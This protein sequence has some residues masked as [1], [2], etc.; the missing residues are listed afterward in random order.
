MRHPPVGIDGGMNAGALGAGVPAAA[1]VRLAITEKNPGYHAHDGIHGDGEGSV[2]LRAKVVWGRETDVNRASSRAA[3][4]GA[5][6]V[7]RTL[8]GLELTLVSGE[9]ASELLARPKPLAVLVYL[10]L[11][12]RNGMQSRD[13]LLDMFWPEAAADRA[14]SSL[15]QATYQ[16]R[17]FLGRDAIV[18]RG[19]EVGITADALQCDTLDFERRLALGDRA[20]ALE[21]YRGDLLPGFF[22]DGAPAFERWLGERR[23]RLRDAA[24]SAAQALAQ[25]AERAGDEASA[26]IWNRRAV[27]L[28]PD[29]EPSVRRLM[30]LLDRAGDRAGAVRAYE[31]FARHMRAVLDLEPSDETAAL[32]ATMRGEP[33]QTSGR[34]TS[35]DTRRVLV[36]AFDNESACDGLGP[37]GRLLA[38]ALATSIARLEGVQVVPLTAALASTRHEERG[39][40]LASGAA[41]ARAAAADAGAATVVT[42]AYY[43]AEGQVMIQG[44]II[45]ARVGLVINALGPASA[46]V[47]HPLAA[48]DALCDEARTT[49]ARR[50]ET[51]VTHVRAAARAPSYEAHVEYVEGIGRFVDGDWRRAL[52][53][54]ERA[55]TR[56][57]SYAL[58][59]IVSA[60]A[61]WNLGELPSADDAVR[62]AGPLAAVA[63]P[64]ERALLDMVRAWLSG[65]WGTAY[66]AVRRQSELAPGSIAVF[67]M[68]EEAR[69]RNRPREAL[70]LLATL[71]PARGEMRGWVF[72]WVVM[73]QAL[74]MVGDHA[75]E[76]DVAR[77][78]RALHP[79]SALALR[80]EVHARSALGDVTGV[81][82]CIAESLAAPARQAPCPGTLMR[83]AAL[84]LRAHPGAD[85]AADALLRQSLAWWEE[86]PHDACAPGVV[87]RATARARYDVGDWDGAA[88]AF[89]TLAGERVVVADC[90]AAHHPHLQAHL[91]HG[92]LGMIAIRRGDGAGAARI[93]ALLA[94]ARS[95]HLFGS[96]HYWRATMAALR[97]DADA[98]V[99][100]LRRAFADGLP[101]EAFIH[102]DLHLDPLRASG[103]LD[104]VLAPR[105]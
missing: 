92:Y 19:V 99:R 22:V 90:G 25:A 17:R 95:E 64:F 87:R 85:D 21:L 37:L 51:R 84:E 47:E 18:H 79:E 14:Q 63:G 57:P 66:E 5:S 60:I 53:H 24:S 97:G 102:A 41:R 86:L 93:D 38:D 98:A 40:V 16:L 67:Q 68:A 72:Y 104:S 7:L 12:G 82:A 26:L 34:P 100:L 10:A 49:P 103:V 83:E 6:A 2:A 88:A 73:A 58:P 27:E 56:D 55:A 81:M 35:L 3:A 52:Y 9:V 69:R 8:G 33:L 105:G 71:D 77:R 101:H 89:G 59:L 13:T 50:F 74:H 96:T 23:Q 43:V 91:D 70:R 30:A 80:L 36:T 75:R 46:P 4:S 39:P 1:D 54:F 48:V 42:G 76:L 61:R 62:R 28:I 11:A 20:G 65:D 31:A 32:V 45:D 44:W 15:R 29:D 78:A 94:G